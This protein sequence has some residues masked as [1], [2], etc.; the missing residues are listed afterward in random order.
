MSFTQRPGM[1]TIRNSKEGNDEISFE[2]TKRESVQSLRK[3]SSKKIEDC[4]KEEEYEMQ[5]EEDIPEEP[6]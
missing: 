5:F 2:L 1:S 6:S 3:K 4:S